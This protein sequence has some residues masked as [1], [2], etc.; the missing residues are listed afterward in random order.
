MKAK[1]LSI[2]KL[3]TKDGSILYRTF[4]VLSDGT[5]GNFY[6]S[7]LFKEGEEVTFTLS[8]DRECKFIV[9]PIIPH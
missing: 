5:V 8:I 1:V 4:A 6:T 9:R 3:T 7:H 2:Q